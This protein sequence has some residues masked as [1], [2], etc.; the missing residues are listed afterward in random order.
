[1]RTWN[2]CYQISYSLLLSFGWHRGTNGLKNW[3]HW[4]YWEDTCFG[5]MWHCC[6][7]IKMC[8]DVSEEPAVN[9]QG[10]YPT[11]ADPL[12]R[13]FISSNIHGCTLSCHKFCYNLHVVHS[14]RQLSRR[15]VRMAVLD[16]SPFRYSSKARNGSSS[17]TQ[18]L[19]HKAKTT[20]EW[21][22]RNPLAFISVE[23]WSSDSA[24]VTPWTINCELC[25]LFWMTWRAESITTAWTAWRDPLWR[26]RHRTHWRRF[27]R[28]AEWPERL[29][30]C[31]EEQGG[32]FEWHYYKWKLKTIA[33]KLFGSKG[34]WFV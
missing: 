32:H 6:V 13:P 10:H 8:A 19:P 27:V 14:W 21:L 9:L 28:T 31:V 4:S 26:Q 15:V 22:R 23:N 3:S 33:N 30:A 16:C 5:G 18:L 1:M 25:G 17:R 7:V 29:K 24:D 12:K 34:G 11:A 20:Q 2:L